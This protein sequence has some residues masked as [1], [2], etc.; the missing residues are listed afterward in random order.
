MFIP[1][2]TCQ[3]YQRT[4]KRDVFSNHSYYPAVATPC[5]VVTLDLKV[6]KTPLREGASGTRGRAEEEVGLIRLLFLPNCPIAEGDLVQV[7]NQIGEAIR[8]FPRR[9]ILGKI[10]HIQVDFR[11]GALPQ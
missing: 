4:G 8:L 1:N 7:E 3:F 9:N 2:A 11:K 6:T 10:D 5:S